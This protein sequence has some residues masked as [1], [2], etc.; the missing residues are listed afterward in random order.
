MALVAV[1]GPL[2]NFLIAAL[3]A[4][5]VFNVQLDGTAYDVVV[6]AL[7]VNIT[8]FLFNLLP[9]PPLDGSRIVGAVM[10]D[11][12]Y[13]RL[14]L[15]RSLRGGGRARRRADLQP[16]VPGHPDRLLGGGRALPPYPRRLG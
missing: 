16:A 6:L 12:T 10:D 3:F 7:L 2:T 9:I 8:L 14:A 13:D 11:R 1:A 15:V 5:I 4:A